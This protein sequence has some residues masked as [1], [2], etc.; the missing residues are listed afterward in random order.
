MAFSGAVSLGFAAF[1]RF[2]AALDEGLGFFTA[3]VFL[4]DFLAI[5]WDFHF[6]EINAFTLP[7]IFSNTDVSL[8]FATSVNNAV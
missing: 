2:K 3:F 6:P 7:F 1:I 4:L 8:F 5:E